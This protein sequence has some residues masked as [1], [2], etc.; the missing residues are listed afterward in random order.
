M[1]FVRYTMLDKDGRETDPVVSN[2]YAGEPLAMLYNAESRIACANNYVTDLKIK[3]PGVPR[4]ILDRAT[5]YAQNLEDLIKIVSNKDRAVGHIYH[6]VE[7]TEENPR[8]ANL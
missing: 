8:Y 1:V 2:P 6:C 5:N 7:L 3:M 4:S